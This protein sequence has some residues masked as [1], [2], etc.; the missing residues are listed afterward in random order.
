MNQYS[1]LPSV[2]RGWWIAQCL[3][4][5]AALAWS[6]GA[7]A[8]T[9]GSDFV[10]AGPGGDTTWYVDV[11][12]DGAVCTNI[13]CFEGVS[14]PE[15]GQ[16]MYTGIANFDGTWL[17]DQPSAEYATGVNGTTVTL[18]PQTLLGMNVRVQYKFFNDRR[19]ARVLVIMANPTMSDVSTNYIHATYYGDMAHHGVRGTSSGDTTMNSADRWVVASDSA[20]NPP[21]RPVVTTVFYGPGPVVA[22]PDDANS[23]DTLSYARFPIT[24]PAGQTRALMFFTGLDNL[25]GGPG[26]GTNEA[27]VASA[28]LF[29]D[30]DAFE[31]QGLLTDFAGVQP[32]EV[33]NWA[34]EAV[35]ITPDPFNVNDKTE[36]TAD[37]IVEAQAITVTGIDTPAPVTLGGAALNSQFQTTTNAT[38]RTTGV[39]S[40]N[41]GLK[42]RHRSA[43]TPNTVATTTLCIGPD[44][45]PVCDDF[46]TTTAASD[47][48]APQPY[49][50]SGKSGLELSVEVISLAVGITGYQVAAPATID[51]GEFRIDGGAWITAGMVPPNS[52]I[53][54]RHT[55]SANSLTDVTSTLTVGG[56]SGSFTS[57]TG[58]AVP[59]V[60]T[61]IAHRDQPANTLVE[62]APVTIKGITIQTP[63]RVTGGEVR[64][65]N[66]PWTTGPVVVE[67]NSVVRV[68]H[69]TAGTDLTDTT[70]TLC[71]G[72][73][74]QQVCRS[75]VSTTQD[76]TDFTPDAFGWPSKTNVPV[77]TVTNSQFKV[78]SGF[79]G[80]LTLTI[81]VGEFRVANGP[82]TTSAD[83][84]SGTNVQVRH[85]SAGTANTSTVSTL[86][87]GGVSGSFTTTTAP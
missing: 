15:G 70:T 9:K 27:A 43:A 87:L 75:Y 10:V 62:S 24:V 32:Q 77:N 36:V 52:A 82:W 4:A 20:M 46:N 25:V 17:T 61:Y 23:F 85:T 63:A 60:F 48:A 19:L 56:V 59:D 71:V 41:E 83:I 80:P 67:N 53:R 40:N 3:S 51:V 69:T 42:V 84:V 16:S 22:P 5:C 55:T 39:V 2:R 28:A 74:A 79:Y 11:G 7:S 58:D 50:F 21:D 78:I 44:S 12:A 30:S 26:A 45:G 76:T 14:T 35:D 86:T 33:L 72:P 47:D 34:L 49:Y 29:D 38:W 8:I 31:M 64:V 65:G 81:D 37:T 6:F 13:V 66:G 73:V 1:T 68:R 18:G 54:I 57:R